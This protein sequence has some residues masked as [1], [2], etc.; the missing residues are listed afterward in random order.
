MKVALL[1]T[2]AL[3]SN[4]LTAQPA[5]PSSAPEALQFDFWIGEWDLTWNDTIKGEN[6]V[7]KEMD[8]C[9][10]F[11]HFNNPLNQYRGWSWSVYNVQTRQWQQTWVDNSG[12]YILLTGGM[13][14]DKMILATADD[15]TAS[16]TLRRMVFYNISKNSFDWTWEASDDNGK[17]W[18]V[19]WKIHYQRKK[20]IET[21]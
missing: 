17:T 14:S 18:H 4:N 11:E 8:G 13:E 5:G 12:D 10:I 3:L 7:T 9:V 15:K 16:G 6:S 20:Q 19:K 21:K 2:A 1:L